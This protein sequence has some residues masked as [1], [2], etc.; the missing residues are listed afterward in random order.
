MMLVRQLCTLIVSV[1]GILLMAILFMLGTEAGLQL[2][3]KGAQWA[4]PGE[5][6]IVGLEGKLFQTIQFKSIHYTRDTQT[7]TAEQGE[8]VFSPNL[9]KRF[10]HVQSLKLNTLTIKQT[11][12]IPQS[13]NQ[14]TLNL[15]YLPTLHLNNMQV[16]AFNYQTPELLIAAEK[17][18]SDIV[19]DTA[20]QLEA[21]AAL[22]NITA[23]DL[24]T[25]TLNQSRVMAEGNYGEIHQL[26]IDSRVKKTG[27]GLLLNLSELSFDVHVDT[28]LDQNPVASIKIDSIKGQLLDAAVTGQLDLTYQNNLWT[29]AQTLNIGGNT[30]TSTGTLSDEWAMTFNIDA[31]NLVLVEKAPSTISGKG[32][33]TGQKLTPEIELNINVNKL[34]APGFTIKK[35]FSLNFVLT[36]VNQTDW[37]LDASVS[38]FPLAALARRLPGEVEINDV[39]DGTLA[40]QGH[41][42]TLTAL[43]GRASLAET[44]VTVISH[45]EGESKLPLKKTAL[46]LDYLDEALILKF[47]TQIGDHP[48][49]KAGFK[50]SQWSSLTDP[51]LDKPFEG[52]IQFNTDDIGW[53]GI[54]LPLDEAIYGEG[55]ANLSLSGT[56]RNPTIQGQAVLTNI[57]MGLKHLGLD[58]TQGS[59]TLNI[60]ERNEYTVTGSI[61]SGDGTLQLNGNG[62]L[63]PDATRDRITLKGNQIVVAN[64]NEFQIQADIDLD[65]TKT[66]EHW[67]LTGDINIPKALIQP[68][69]ISSDTQELSRDVVFTDSKAKAADQSYDFPLHSK[70]N[71]TLG[72]NVVFSFNALTTGVSGKLEVID[73]PELPTRAT[74]E[75]N[76]NKSSVRILNQSLDVKRGKLIFEG[77]LI[78]DPFLDI[79]ISKR[80]TNISQP[81]QLS[82]L[83]N[84]LFQIPSI[85]GTTTLIVG[86][87]LTGHLKD[88]KFDFF[89]SPAGLPKKEI[90]SYL[91]LGD[92]VSGLAQN[93]VGLLIKAASL[94]KF[95]GSEKADLIGSVDNKKIKLSDFSIDTIEADPS[96]AGDTQTTPALS[97]GKFL[98]PKLYLK[99]SVGLMSPASALQLQ[100]RVKEKWLI[101]TETNQRES[102]ID[103]LY[104]FEKD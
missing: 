16:G 9:F 17:L 54:F 95:A 37:L 25:I 36:W 53:L 96:A 61:R 84:T 73:G 39:V 69:K 24:P 80:L 97:L 13:E 72:K 92:S 103:V 83:N 59:L 90:L 82:G 56:M 7:I 98:S 3:A 88:P 4:L 93:Q 29:L 58:L 22:I 77:G 100:Y 28:N 65:L 5:L 87:R 67:E 62:T 43:K 45:T 70:I 10:N 52:K 102:A 38:E 104:S 19:I 44:T 42:T 11:G 18:A 1:I 26:Q 57:R 71:L 55:K 86:A 12:A 99:Y 76:L 91:L 49:L 31:P 46:M 85:A 8:L 64:T 89:S 35:P 6:E 51:L 21:T 79:E 63:N 23:K 32:T 20:S 30:I 81:M 94:T 47:T 48:P 66:P 14:G 50:V 27:Q 60:N 41:G 101:Q 74:G 33:I 2:L 75:L 15:R 78:E 40:A 34:N 68:E